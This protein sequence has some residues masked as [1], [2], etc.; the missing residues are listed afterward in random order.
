MSG[1]DRGR[2][3]IDASMYDS[4]G[5]KKAGAKA[6]GVGGGRRDGGTKGQEKQG[7]R[8]GF[9]W[10]M[11]PRERLERNV[12]MVG[13]GDVVR[14]VLRLCGAASYAAV[15]EVGEDH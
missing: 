9:E 2:E 8:R 4:G 6:S 14:V 7:G 3:E 5:H 13:R 1:T 12:F 10:D 11:T 15:V